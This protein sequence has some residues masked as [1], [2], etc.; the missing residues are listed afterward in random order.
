MNTKKMVTN[1]ILI[2]VGAIL[3]LIT[4]SFF[5]VQCDF[6]L[7]MLFI[8][9]VVNKD[10][11]TTLICGIVIGIFA[12]YTSKLGGMA[13]VPN[14]VDKLITSNIMYL[15]LMPLRNNIS[16]IKQVSILLP[17]GTLVSG[18]TFLT[19]LMMLSGLPGG[20]SFQALFLSVVV[21]TI[22]INTI[23]GIVIFKIVEKIALTSGA[24]AMQ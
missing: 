17:V 22:V 16:Q 15:V 7:T 2:A 4:P 11:K 9:I 19:V 5:G 18:V 13:I 23:L 1:A 24:Y 14:I 21:P 8:I 10:Y 12:A 6:S 3:H 20:M